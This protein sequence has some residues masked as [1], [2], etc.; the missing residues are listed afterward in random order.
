MEIEELRELVTNQKNQ[1]AENKNTIEALQDKANQDKLT[2]EELNKQITDLK[3]KN[4]DLFLK[5]VQ[6]PIQQQ[7]QQTQ[8]IQQEHVM[9]VADLTYK[10]LNY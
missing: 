6:E 1:I 4:H 5:V 2:I 10:L 3:V 7:T 8:Q 9:S